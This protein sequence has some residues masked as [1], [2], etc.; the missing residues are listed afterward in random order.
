M[1][2]DNLIIDRDANEVQIIDH[3][4]GQRLNL[5][6]AQARFIFVWLMSFLNVERAILK[7]GVDVEATTTFEK[8]KRYL[9]E[10]NSRDSGL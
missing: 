2:L 8:V 4:T 6:R 3:K 9:D 10:I 7:N 5:N 1:R